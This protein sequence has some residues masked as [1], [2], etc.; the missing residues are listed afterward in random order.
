MRLFTLVSWR[1]A[2]LP[3]SLVKSL[4][5]QRSLSSP[6]ASLYL[7]NVEWQF[8]TLNLQGKSFW[9]LQVI[10]QVL[11]SLTTSER[12]VDDALQLLINIQN[13]NKSLTICFVVVVDVISEHRNLENLHQLLSAKHDHLDKS[14]WS[15]ISFEGNS[16]SSQLPRPRMLSKLIFMRSQADFWSTSVNV[17]DR[18]CW[19]ATG[20][21]FFFATRLQWK[22]VDQV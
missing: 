20:C 1:K 18:T 2:K 10:N 19:K 16:R 9:C 8:K 17:S 6:P 3:R 13:E 4:Q 11:E 7:D 15:E 12:A 22:H 21:C 5:F 14:S